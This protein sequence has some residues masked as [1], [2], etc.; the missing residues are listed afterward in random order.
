MTRVVLVVVV[1]LQTRET[2]EKLVINNFQCG[3]DHLAYE[4]YMLPFVGGP[5][6]MMILLLRLCLDYQV[7]LLD[8]KG[9]VVVHLGS[10]RWRT[11]CHSYQ[12]EN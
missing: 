6:T 5:R 7:L 8:E 12:S 2:R 10:S 1:V 11:R 4:I 9:E 3:Q